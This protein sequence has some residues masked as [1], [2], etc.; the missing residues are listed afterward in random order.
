MSESATLQ[1][2]E[3]DLEAVA[4]HRVVRQRTEVFVGR[5]GRC[6]QHVRCFAVM[7]RQHGQAQPEPGEV[8]LA[9]GGGVAEL[10]VGAEHGVGLCHPVGDRLVG[11]R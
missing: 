4:Q 6:P 8:A 2:R 11:G 3:V 5:R 7:P 1:S 9:D 10:P